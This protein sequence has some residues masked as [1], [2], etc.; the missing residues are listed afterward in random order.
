MSCVASS[1][2]NIDIF[3]LQ[4]ADL[5]RYIPL[6]VLFTHTVDTSIHP[7]FADISAGVL[8]EEFQTDSWLSQ[9]WTYYPGAFSRK[10]TPTCQNLHHVSQSELKISIVSF[11]HAVS[12][13]FSVYTFW[14]HIVLLKRLTHR[15]QQKIHNA[16]LRLPKMTR[17]SALRAGTSS[18]SYISLT[19]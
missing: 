14:W 16:I 7:L 13:S 9:L 10:D 6:S 18:K 19:L 5:S 3:Y 12:L 2:Y 11:S 17:F 8:Y 15:A 1:I 4:Y